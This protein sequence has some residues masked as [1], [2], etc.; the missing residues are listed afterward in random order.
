MARDVIQRLADVGVRIGVV[1]ALVAIWILGTS[2]GRLNP[3]FY[4]SASGLAV[5][6]QDWISGGQIWVDVGH[7]ML[8]LTL[9]MIVGTAGGVALGVLFFALPLLRDAAEPIVAFANGLPRLILYPIFALMLGFSIQAKVLSVALVIVFLSQ[10]NTLA[11]LT[12]TD[13]RLIDNI[14]IAGGSRWD[15]AWLVYAPSIFTWLTAGSRASVGLAFQAVIVT[16]MIGSVAG[17]GRMA[18]IGQ[19]TFN[20]NVILAAVVVMVLVAIT[21][22]VL[23]SQAEKRALRWRTDEKEDR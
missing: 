12:E 9:G 22:D 17:L 11:G 10:A 5:A 7:S 15:V 8:V 19:G 4:G 13:R 20:V 1:V 2:T 21:I 16:E 14:R 18:A 6:M 23:L 3:F